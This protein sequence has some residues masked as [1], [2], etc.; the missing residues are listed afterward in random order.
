MEI[1]GAAALITG[2]ASGLGEAT[3]ALLH[4]RGAGVVVADLNREKGEEL[5]GKLGDGA[6]F[7]QTD[8]TNS[9][10][11]KGAVDFT[12]ERFGAVN[13][14]VNCAG[15][16]L[17]MRT[18]SRSGPH[19]LGLFKKVLEINLVG[20]FDMI[21]LSAEKMAAQEPSRWGERGV[22]INTASA[23][24]FEGQ[25][26]QAAYSASKAGIAGMT[27]TLAR[28]LSGL[29]IRVCTIAPGLF[30]TPLLAALPEEAKASLGKM[31]P[32]PPRLGKPE[33]YAVLAAQVIENVMLNGETI[34]L[35]GALR[36][37]PR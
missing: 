5:A 23:A 6:A 31:V 11:V 13:I 12:V 28:D 7:F 14:L 37:A 16:G 17:A 33:E 2:G 32:F 20:T 19:D 22:I 25:I 15:I 30:D 1:K 18:L 8:V 3:A 9:D 26:G 24:A 34:R 21:R 35:D 27:L 29:G 10:Q 4:A 36:M